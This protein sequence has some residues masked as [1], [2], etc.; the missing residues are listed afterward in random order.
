MRQLPSGS[1]AL[2][3]ELDGLDDVLALYAALSD[4]PPPAPCC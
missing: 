1:A 3:V 2:L 4:A